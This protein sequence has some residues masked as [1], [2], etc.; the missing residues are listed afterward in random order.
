MHRQRNNSRVHDI[1]EP[2]KFYASHITKP[3]Y[4]K[5]QKHTFRYASAHI[6]NKLIEGILCSTIL[7]PQ[8]YFVTN[9]VFIFIEIHDILRKMDNPSGMFIFEILYLQDASAIKFMT[10][11]Y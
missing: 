2:R 1:F 5:V 9:N 7:T 4:N 3:F 6:S 11:L 10:N 8:K